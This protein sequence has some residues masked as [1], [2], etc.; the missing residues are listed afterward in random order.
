LVIRRHERSGWQS[1]GC[2]FDQSA[3]SPSP[4]ATGS[5]VRS[6]DDEMKTSFFASAFVALGALGS[7]A[8]AAPIVHDGIPKFSAI[9][10]NQGQATT[11]TSA[12]VTLTGVSAPR[13]VLSNMFDNDILSAYSLGLGGTGAGG[14][15]ELVISPT[16]NII[17]SGSLIEWTNSGTDHQ[18][19]AFVALGVDGGGY[20]TIGQIFNT[21]FGGPAT[22][23]NIAPGI[24][25]LSIGAD[26]GSNHTRFLL[27]VTSGAFNSLRFQDDSPYV[28]GLNG[29]KNRDGFDIAELR[30]TSVVPEPN[31][32]VLAGAALIL[33]G[34]VRRYGTNRPSG[35]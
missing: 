4:V 10:A 14:T 29:T 11:N 27:T 17:S 28:T 22:I 9:V 19:R 24:A 13:S 12:P 15:L 1:Q 6:K 2:L 32:L 18:E 5:I 16:T 25:T 20:V 3:L 33:L 7:V 31:A 30:V 35:T 34:F 23:S 26:P 8:N 21:E